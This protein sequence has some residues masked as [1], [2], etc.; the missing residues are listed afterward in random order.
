MT[1]FFF[2]K[3]NKSRIAAIIYGVLKI[4]KFKKQASNKF[5][6]KNINPET[7]GLKPLFSA[8]F[9]FFFVFEKL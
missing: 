3:N 5:K 8:M 7:S 4:T 9:E 6:N 1:I 2:V